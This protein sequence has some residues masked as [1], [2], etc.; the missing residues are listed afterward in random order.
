MADYPEGFDLP[1]GTEADAA[2][3]APDPSQ[4]DTP[5]GDMGMVEGIFGAIDGAIDGW[6]GRINDINVAVAEDPCRAVV[7][8]ANYA[9]GPASVRTQLRK[10]EATAVVL[11]EMGARAV[12]RAIDRWGRPSSL[13]EGGMPFAAWLI[14]TNAVSSSAAAGLAFVLTGSPVAA[15]VLTGNF[16]SWVDD[17]IPSSA[18]P[19]AAARGVEVSP[20]AWLYAGPGRTAVQHL[21]QGRWTGP[22]IREAWEDWTEHEAAAVYPPRFS[23]WR[24]KL[25]RLAGSG[26]APGEPVGPG[27]LIESLRAADDDLREWQQLSQDE[28]DLDRELQRETERR[29]VDLEELRARRDPRAQLLGARGI[30][31]AVRGARR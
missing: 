3:D 25:T 27:S 17:R 16:A 12:D 5:S 15:A 29:R 22:T 6:S 20:G 30:A 23:Q 31:A 14:D 19:P 13:Y 18:P 10:A 26:W 21:D 11:Y 9:A 7:D 28:C 1:T 8:L 2:A 4:L 24:A